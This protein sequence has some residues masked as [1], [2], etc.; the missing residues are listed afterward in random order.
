MKNKKPPK[1]FR[2]LSPE[3]L[4]RELDYI[5]RSVR[6][7]RRFATGFEP[8]AG[9]DLHHPERIHPSRIA[10]VKRLVP[11]IRKMESMPHRVVRP[12][13]KESFR[14]LRFHTRQSFPGQKAFFVH[15]LKPENTRVVVRN[16]SVR[17]VKTIGKKKLVTQYFYLPRLRAT[18]D[19]II[20]DTKKLLLPKMPKGYYTL[21]SSVY[22]TIGE[23]MQKDRILSE[24]RDYWGQYEIREGERRAPGSNQ[25][26][27]FASTIIGFRRIGLNDEAAMKYSRE[28]R[29]D[30]QF[31]KDNWDKVYGKKKQKPTKRGRLTGRR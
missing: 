19:Q 28:V 17:E 20:E 30:R 2:S 29:R 9:Y 7:A 25:S 16:G 13:S 4:A 24:L 10:K 12:R 5:K 6:L 15:V 3:Q 31:W 26:Y 18:M 1:R 8:D 23:P 22:G 14:A 11:L 27:T 21:Q